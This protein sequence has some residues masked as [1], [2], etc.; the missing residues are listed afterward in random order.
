[1]PLAERGPAA[2]LGFLARGFRLVFLRGARRYVF[3]PFAVN[4]ALFSIAIWF[5]W[6]RIRQ[7]LGLLQDWTPAWLDWIS[8]VLLPMATIVIVVIVYYS[9]TLV[10]N[11][12]AAPFN[13][14]LA[15]KIESLLRGQPLP[16]G[17]GFRKLPEIAGRTLL[18]E[19][20]KLGYQLIW[21]VPL[22]ILTLTPAINVIAPLAWFVFGAWMMAVNYLDYPMGNHDH[23]FADVRRHLRKQRGTAI[24][25]G[26]GL[27]IM[28]LVPVLNF[29]A[30]PVGVAGAT[31]MW[32]ANPPEGF[33]RS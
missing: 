17:S 6:N 14:L 25:F 7:W 22:G 27:V 21:F 30:M 3:V 26:S 4:T 5:I 10:A 33:G 2:G 32:V 29:L 31:A 23:Y 28:T 12:I 19:L 11:L 18:S 9:F 20:R 24:G 1:M 15:E 13:S 16:P 8:W